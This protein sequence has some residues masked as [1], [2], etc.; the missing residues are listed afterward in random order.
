[1]PMAEAPPT[2]K[3]LLRCAG[4]HLGKRRA[5]VCRHP[6]G[7]CAMLV[8]QLTLVCPWCRSVN[9]FTFHGAEEHEQTVEPPGL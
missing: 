3:T 1:M 6:L 5:K 9:Q 2:V 7:G 4:I 8:G